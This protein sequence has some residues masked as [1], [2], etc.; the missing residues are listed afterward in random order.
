[1]QGFLLSGTCFVA[2]QL[3]LEYARQWHIEGGSNP[4]P[5]IL[6]TLQNWAKLNLIVKTVKNC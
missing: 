2:L 6:K 5:E 1:M 4:P 3:P